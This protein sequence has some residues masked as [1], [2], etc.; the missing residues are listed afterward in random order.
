[1]E[2]KV[3]EQLLRILENNA[4]L[5]VED[6]A[7]MLDKST[8]EVAAMIGA[9]ACV[10]YSEIPFAGPI[11]ALEVG[12]VDG[13]IVLNP[14][15]EQ[16]KTSRMDVTVAATA[17]KVVMIEAGADEIPDEIMYA[18][19]VKA[20]EE[21]KKQIDFINQIVAEIGKPKMEYEHADFNQELFDDIVAN[22]MDEAKA[23][24]DTDDK[25]VR[26]ERWNA[27]IDKW[28]E[29]YLEQYPDLRIDTLHA[30]Q[31][32]LMSSKSFEFSLPEIISL[33]KPYTGEPIPLVSFNK[34][35][36]MTAETQQLLLNKNIIQILLEAPVISLIHAYIYQGV[37]AAICM[38]LGSDKPVTSID[39]N[40]VTFTPIE[41]ERKASLVLF[42]NRN[43]P[44][45][46]RLILLHHLHAHLSFM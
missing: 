34:S 23:A 11:G 16:R 13:Q 29:K 31:F 41:T 37:A 19:I 10:S 8:A 38:S 2:N 40:R 24:M 4:R 27:M 42:S 5:P 17:E 44:E 36:P 26:E 43:I 45:E 32:M 14:N 35:V 25:N 46:I 15:Q 3:M 28:R 30:V 20:H 9:S 1:M 12:Y 21:I 33:T 6:I 7:A 39:R 22:F 18:G